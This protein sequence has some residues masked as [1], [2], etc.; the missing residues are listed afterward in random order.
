MNDISCNV[1]QAYDYNVKLT[2]KEVGK[3]L[4]R[5]MAKVM[6]KLIKDAKSNLRKAYKN[7]NKVNPK[8]NDTLISGVRASKVYTDPKDGSVYSYGKIKRKRNKGSGAFR[9]LFLE[10]GA[11]NRQTRKG[12]NRGTVTGKWF[13]GQAVNRNEST[14]N[15]DIIKAINDAIDRINAAR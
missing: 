6:R 8:Y 2:T 11:F 1:A 5:G 3:T 13:F 12:Y 15:Q 4:K 7:V 10:Q 14:F 9:L